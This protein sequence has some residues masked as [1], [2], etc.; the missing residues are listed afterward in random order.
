M[1]HVPQPH[2][3]RWEKPVSA[4]MKPHFSQKETGLQAA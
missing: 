4:A 2:I 1:L 3:S